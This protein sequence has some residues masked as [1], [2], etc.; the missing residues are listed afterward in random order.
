[1][2]PCVRPSVTLPGPGIPECV[3]PIWID[4]QRGDTTPI[5]FNRVESECALLCVS[6]C[7]QSGYF[8]RH[9][10]LFS[11]SFD[12]M[13]LRFPEYFTSNN[14]RN[15][16]RSRDS[17]AVAPLTSIYSERCTLISDTYSLRWIN[18]MSHLV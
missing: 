7:H 1:M 6:A 10:R 2:C 5:E 8:L 11:R 12:V 4:A 18:L 3:T 9:Q 17:P 14:D 16:L 15:F 13:L